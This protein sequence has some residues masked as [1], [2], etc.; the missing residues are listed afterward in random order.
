MKLLGN[1]FL[2]VSCFLT[3][4]TFAVEAQV[5]KVDTKAKTKPT[6]VVLGT[7]R[8]ETAGNSGANPESA[9]VTTPERQKQIAALVEKLKKIKPTKIAL[10]C[11]IT[12]DP[13]VN[14][15]FNQYL[16]GSYQLSKNETN[17]IGFR[18]AKELSCVRSM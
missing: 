2:F 14:N 16:S 15:A 18:L 10:E 11:D 13:K 17:L 3:L 5:G 8:M 4:S 9:D 1:H 12:N 7:Y 6:L